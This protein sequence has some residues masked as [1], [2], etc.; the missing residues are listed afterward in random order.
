[1]TSSFNDQ[2]PQA[3]TNET[4]AVVNK[5]DKLDTDSKLAWF[6]LVY[7]RMGDSITR[8]APLAAEP[9]LAPMLVQDYLEFSDDQQLKIMREV[10]EGA[11]T[12]YSR[13][14]GA[15][16]DNNQLL[17]WYI[18]AEAMGD[19]VVGMPSDYQASDSINDLLS[20]IE[21]LEFEGQMSVFRTI[22]N[23]MGHTNVKPIETQAVTGKT[24]SF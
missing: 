23:Q 20:Q 9:E 13:T 2:I 11:D 5:F 17:I 22:V 18:W 10:V 4:Q 3:L 24:S 16:K 19:T 6:Y 8:A 7:K 14:Y 12:D 21:K 15:L 1:M